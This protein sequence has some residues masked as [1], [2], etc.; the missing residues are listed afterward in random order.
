[1]FKFICA[2]FNHIQPWSHSTANAG[3]VAIHR[4]DVPV[5]QHMCC[6]D[7]CHPQH[8]CTNIPDVQHPLP[9]SIVDATNTSVEE[10]QQ[11]Q[12]VECG[13]TILTLNHKRLLESKEE[14][15][16]DGI[17]T[18]AQN[19]L[20]Q[21]FTIRGLQAP[22]LGEE[23][24]MEVQPG[25][26]LQIMCVNGNHWICVSTIGCPSSTIHVYDSMHGSLHTHTQKL[27]ADLM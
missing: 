27:V 1:M 2:S 20:K 18:A 11:D 8:T 22:M 9:L 21:Q 3:L 24:R 6:G 25:E 15:L 13:G 14:W 4:R 19:I 7:M 12:W 5:R 17:I 23:L 26:F 16:D 10:T